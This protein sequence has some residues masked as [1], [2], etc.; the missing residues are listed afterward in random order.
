MMTWL[1]RLLVVAAS[2]LV[3]ITSVAA[4][5]AA[6]PRWSIALHGGAGVITPDQMTPEREA[7]YRASLNEALSAGAAVLDAGGSA[8]DA[9]EAAIRVME[10]DPLFNAGRGAVFTAAGRN[11]LDASIMDGADLDAGAVAGVTGVRHPITLARAVM[12]NSRHVMLQGEGAERFADEQG[13]E[14]VDPA[15]FYTQRRWNS[16]SATLTEQGAPLPDLPDGITP[17]SLDEEPEDK[18]DARKHG[19]V[20]VVARDA[21]GNLAA[22]TSTGGMTAKR[23][24]RVGD[25]PIIGAGTY[26]DNRT[27][28]VS[29]TG[30]GEY[31][32]RLGIAQRICLRMQL[33]GEDAQRAGDHVI[34]EELGPLG[35]D[36]GVI[37]MDAEGNAFYSFNT[38]GM[39]RARQNADTPA[40]VDIYGMPGE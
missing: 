29:S 17:A 10:D 5:E 15:F 21:Q 25:S 34:H 13:V 39:Y 37:I 7:A 24:G 40:Q 30:W 4:D 36:G 11:E 14:R 9:V 3:G 2:A 16:M 26:A 1:F 35:G 33:L 19:T 22:G 32:I 12:E 18:G 23:W 28:A 8:L 27:C 31:F 20:G 38:R 6:S